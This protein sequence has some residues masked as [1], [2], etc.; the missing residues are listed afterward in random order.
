MASAVGE[1]WGEAWYRILYNPMAAFRGG[2]LSAVAIVRF[3]FRVVCVPLCVWGSARSA[4][5]HFG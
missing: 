5:P 4:T 3:L 2:V 1:A